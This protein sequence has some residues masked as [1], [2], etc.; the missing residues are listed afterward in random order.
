M[1]EIS[2]LVRVKMLDEKA[3]HILMLKLKILGKFSYI[4]C[5]KQ[6][7]GNSDI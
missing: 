6:L 7:L 3:Q 2:G 5:N 4:I 1:D